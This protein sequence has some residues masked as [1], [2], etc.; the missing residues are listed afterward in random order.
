MLVKVKVPPSG[1]IKSYINKPVTDRRSF[2]KLDNVKEIGKIVDAKEI[3]NSYELT[4][5]I[6][7]LDINIEF[8]S[9]RVRSISIEK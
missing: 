1:N 2:S 8:N 6:T 4:L 7:D 9:D 5:D 3:D